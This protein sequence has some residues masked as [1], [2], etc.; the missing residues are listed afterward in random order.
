MKFKPN[1][2]GV[3]LSLLT[4]GCATPNMASVSIG[5]QGSAYLFRD[6]S[7][8]DG[9]AVLESIPFVVEIR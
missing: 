4:V 5:C 9:M 6:V 8:F 1:A 3:A 2:M 7:V